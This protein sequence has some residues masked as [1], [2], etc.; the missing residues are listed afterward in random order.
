MEPPHPLFHHLEW[1]MVR[2][3]SL[4]MKMKNKSAGRLFSAVGSLFSLE[5][6][7]R[8][9]KRNREAKGDQFTPKWFDQTEEVASTPWGDLEI[10]RYNGKYSDH[11]SAVDSSDA[12]D[13]SDVQ[14][15]EFN[16]W[17]YAELS[18]ITE[19]KISGSFDNGK[20][21]LHHEGYMQTKGGFAFGS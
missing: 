13:T 6:R 16:P 18:D 10:F 12:I 11:R 7:Q 21:M 15:I 19:L 20:H 14:S 5:E 8:A 9:E 4:V 1:L 3:L 17:Q 2:L